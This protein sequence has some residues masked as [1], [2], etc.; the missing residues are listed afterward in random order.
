M[1]P[2]PVT[3]KLMRRIAVT[4]IG[5]TVLASGVVMV[6]MPGPAFIV[7]PVGLAILGLEFAWA[8]VWLRKLRRRISS[9]N[10][11]ARSTRSEQH[12]ERRMNR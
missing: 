3:Y 4:V 11:E 1:N 2:V 12:R 8:R 5:L 7:I 9:N 10:A 6:V